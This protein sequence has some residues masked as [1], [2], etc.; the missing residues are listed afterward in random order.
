MYFKC[1]WCTMFPFTLFYGNLIYF[2]V[3]CYIIPILVYCIKKNLAALFQCRFGK[4]S[5]NKEIVFYKV[6]FADVFCT[7]KWAWN[8]AL[9]QKYLLPGFQPYNLCPTFWLISLFREF[10]E[11]ARFFLVRDTKTGKKCT[12]CTQNESNG[13]KMAQMSVKYSKWP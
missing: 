5:P 10:L 1:I 13:H 2:E 11:V 7:Q 3:I 9:S 12:I 4:Q 8:K 6:L